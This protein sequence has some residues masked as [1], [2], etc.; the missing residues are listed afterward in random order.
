MKTFLCFIFCCIPQNITSGGINNFS[1]YST[2][3]II[4]HPQNGGAD[5]GRQ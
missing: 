4:P 1:A 2:G 5:P 3:S